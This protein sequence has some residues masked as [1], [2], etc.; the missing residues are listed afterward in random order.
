MSQK[1]I[2]QLVKLHGARNRKDI[3]RG[4]K[5]AHRVWNVKKHGEAKF[6][7]FCL[8]QYVPPGKARNQLLE[9][10]DEFHNSI[11]GNMG[12]SVKVA[13]AGQDIADRPLTPAETVLASFSP[14]IHLSED[15]RDANIAALA[16][17]NFGTDDRR[18]P[19]NRPAWAARRMGDLGRTV[20]PAPL[21]A[22]MTE[23]QS[24]VDRFISSYNLHLDRIDFGDRRVKFPRGT[25]LIS[26]WG[27]RDFMMEQ[28]GQ[29]DALVKQRAILGIMERVVDGEIPAEILD[30]PEASWSL[31]DRKVKVGSKS[32]PARG[33]GALRWQQFREV[34]K[35]IRKIDPYRRTGNLIDEKFEI[36][37][38]VSEKKIVKILTDI[39]SSPHAVRVANF[40]SDQL[41]RPLEPFDIYYRDFVKEG[42]GKKPL[43][44][45]I[46][47]RYPTAQALQDAIPD[48]LVKMGWKRPR[49]RWIGS[50]I[51]VDNGRSAGHAWSPRCPEDLQLLRVRVDPGGCSEMSFETFMHE[52]GHCV[53]GVLSSYELDYKCLW[54]VPNTSFT[55]GFA[56]T[57]QDRTDELLGRGKQP[58]SDRQIIQRFWQPFEIGGSALTEIRF[59][60]WLYENPSATAAQMQKAIRRIGDEL[61]EEFYAR[62]FG[63]KSHGLMSIYSHMLWG[64]FYLAEYPLGYVIA[65]QIQ[66]HLEKR[67]LPEEMERMC[68]QG[69]IYPESWMKAAVGSEISVKPLLDDTR[70]ALDSL[71][72]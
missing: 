72:Y 50:K 54:S 5:A 61:W 68:A 60:H 63:P 52:L 33:H 37:R 8:E 58:V 70:K 28:N 21:L 67:K 25:K 66:K 59:F 43:R 69:S 29:P 14:D 51:R 13:R 39:L 15:Y 22:S 48:I 49:A 41:G 53:E 35:Q 38:E 16:Q 10:L 12:M 20:V 57:F 26:H 27:L 42:V 34:W 45:D 9:R 31:P 1:V 55:E 30:N 6:E 23:A 17:L 7:A 56:F 65:Y 40:I 4:V 32:L 11:A 71:G 36:E 64:D 46:R 19:R 47:K 2:Q 44:F 18:P 24:R 62:I 3:E